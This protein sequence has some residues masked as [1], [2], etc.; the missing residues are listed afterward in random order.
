MKLDGQNAKPLYMQLLHELQKDIVLGK[1]PTNSR[2]PSEQ[3]LSEEYQVSRVTVRAA[4]KELTEMGLVVRKQGK[5]TFVM[6]QKLSRDLSLAT[7]FSAACRSMGKVP[8]AKLLSAEMID[9]SQADRETLAMEDGAKVIS[10]R[11]LRYADGVPISVEEDHF[12]VK[13]SF[14]LNEDLEDTSLMELLEK[15][16][17]ITFYNVHRTVELAYAPHPIAQLLNCKAKTPMFYIVSTGMEVGGTTPGERSIQYIIGE[18][19]KLYV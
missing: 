1:Y 4:L 8:G 7:S 18:N 5:G 12:P 9:A 16:Y 13:Y 11:R 15:K 6:P 10:L 14:L 17:H 3:E 2:L 19:F